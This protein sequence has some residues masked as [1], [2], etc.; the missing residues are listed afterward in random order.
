MSP[1]ISR[2]DLLFLPTQSVNASVSPS[3]EPIIDDETGCACLLCL[4]VC[5]RMC[6]SPTS[7]SVWSPSFTCACTSVLLECNCLIIKARSCVYFPWI[8]NQH[9]RICLFNHKH[10]QRVWIR[11]AQHG[12]A[13]KCVHVPQH[14]SRRIPALYANMTRSLADQQTFYMPPCIFQDVHSPV[15]TCVHNCAHLAKEDGIAYGSF[16][17]KKSA[18]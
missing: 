15:H 6:M 3:S 17:A 9:T 18:T 16:R 2:T 12:C 4:S 11:T 14:V 5:M 7:V 13:H 1:N 8:C 10:T